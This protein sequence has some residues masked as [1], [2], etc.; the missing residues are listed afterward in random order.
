VTSRKQDESGVNISAASQPFIVAAML[1]QLAVQSGDRVMEAGAGTGYNAALMA[2]IAGP[3]GHVTTIDVDE[4][5]VTGARE[6]LAAALVTNVDVVLGD[7]ALGHPAGAPYDK[8][9]ATVGAAEV[10]APWLQQLAAGGRLVVPLRFRGTASRSIIFE[11][12]ENGW[13]SNGSCL[14]VFM[15]MRGSHDDARR[16]IALTQEKDVSLQVHLD[17]Q[18]HATALTAVLDT[19]RH[20]EWTRVLFPPDV[21]YEWMDLWLCL[22]L[23]NALM[24][25]NVQQPA[26]DRGQVKPMFPW[27][28]MATADRDSLAYLT[29]RPAPPA[30]DGSKLYEV[31]VFGHGPG[32]RQLARRVSDELCLWNSQYRSRTV[33]FELPDNP[34][35]SDPDSGK[36]VLPRPARPI[37]I[38]WQ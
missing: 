2:A 32:G 25:M 36:F 29:T 26:A 22:R 31:G 17:Q 24:R 23:P 6:H 21:P 27:G 7:G 10:P 9:I 11:R 14:A 15:P 37:T 12:G 35:S 16:V 34:A 18:A 8:I 30:A 28:S 38:T 3:G 19:A 4:D 20:E 5:L 1:E 13:H 33:H